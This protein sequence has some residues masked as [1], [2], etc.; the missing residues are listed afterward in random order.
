M[1]SSL[2]KILFK[3][4][5]YHYEQVEYTVRDS[6]GNTHTETYTEKVVTHRETYS[7]P[8]YSFQD[9]SG[10]FILNQEKM[11]NAVFIKL[12]LDK[13]INFADNISYYDYLMQKQRFYIRNK[14]RDTDLDM[15][16]IREIQDFKK[17]N[18]IKI[19]DKNICTI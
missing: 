17:Y 11:K 9:V 10:L 14:N 8:Y 13:E 2:P 12:E 1:Y 19:R 6:D 7:F 16:E 18:F 15:W 5:C 4:E 3:C